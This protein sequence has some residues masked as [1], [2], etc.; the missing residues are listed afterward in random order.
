VKAEF[1]EH[2][3]TIATVIDPLSLLLQLDLQ[4]HKEFKEFKEFKV[5]RVPKVLLELDKQVH[6][7]MMVQDQQV[8][9][10]SRVLMVPD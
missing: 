6:R 10:A 1:L 3:V 8:H 2:T 4:D 7:V 5:L 9:R